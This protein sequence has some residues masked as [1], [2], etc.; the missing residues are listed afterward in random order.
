M[1]IS[2]SRGLRGAVWSER[3][4][5]HG[6]LWF[7]DDG[8]GL[9]APH[10][11]LAVEDGTGRLCCHLC[12]LWFISLGSHVRV[13]GHNADTYRQTMGLCLSTALTASSLSTTIARRQAQ[14]Y[15]RDPEMRARLDAGRAGRIGLASVT[16][17][18]EPEQRVRRR[19]AALAAGRVTITRRRHE[20]L[21]SRLE[22]LGHDSLHDYLRS[23]YQAGASLQELSRVTGLGRDRL[24][25]EFCDAGLAVR[26]PGSNT[27][28]GKASRALAAE[29]AAGIRVG[30]DDLPGWLADHHDAG[31]SLTRL[32]AAVGHSTHWVRWRL[33]SGTAAPGG[34][35]AGLCGTDLSADLGTGRPALSYDETEGDPMRA[36]PGFLA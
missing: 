14:G 4:G 29:V 5:E 34:V 9:H 7:L 19:R 1:A 25:Q 8:T 32:A 24:R 35:T 21:T 3:S 26:P 27:A 22:S 28:A 16:S 10:G 13:H 23:A 20:E 15:R 31:W 18:P 12:G 33:P 17:K 11:D 6:H 30:T 36:R 2:T